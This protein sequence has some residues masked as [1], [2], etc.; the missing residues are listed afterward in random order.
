MT[1][2]SRDVSVNAVAAVAVAVA[3]VVAA[4]ARAAQELAAELGPSDLAA[5]AGSAVND[6]SERRVAY[7]LLALMTS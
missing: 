2:T 7:K 3:V 6:S 1:R 4:V 5:A